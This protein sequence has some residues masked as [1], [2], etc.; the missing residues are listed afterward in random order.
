MEAAQEVLEAVQ[1]QAAAS[2]RRYSGLN[3]AG[4][5]VRSRDVCTDNTATTVAA[6]GN[7]SWVCGW[8]TGGGFLIMLLPLLVFGYCFVPC[9]PV[10]A[11]FSLARSHCCKLFRGALQKTRRTAA[12]SS[13]A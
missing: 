6:C 3:I 1:D 2:S 9:S 10:M 4:A 8:G 11:S 7:C 5:L 13:H 12:V